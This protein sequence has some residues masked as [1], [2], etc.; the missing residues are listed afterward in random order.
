MEGDG[1]EYPDK[2]GF[3]DTTIDKSDQEMPDILDREE[4]DDIIDAC[5]N[6]RDRAMYKTLY[7][8]GLRAGE[9][10]SLKVGDVNFVDSGVKLNVQGK[11]GSR[12]LLVVESERY[13]RNWLS[14]HPFSNERNAPLWVKVD[15]NNIEE[16]TH[17]DMRLRY[18]YMRIN[19]KRKSAKA[20]VRVER[21]DSGKKSSEVYPHLFRHT[22]ATHLATELTEAAMKEYFGW[23]QGSDQPQTYIHL[24]GR[25]IDGE[26]MKMYGIEDEEEKDQKK[27]CSR[28]MKEYRG[29]ESFCPRCGAPLSQK[30]AMKVEELQNYGQSYVQQRVNGLEMN[31]LEEMIGNF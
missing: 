20:E 10:M 18:D 11:T 15:G 13:L 8:A 30:D 14:K 17:E 3:I 26:I 9:L 5:K 22:R 6:D 29:S 12:K 23:T 25:D 16:K 7:E 21:K 4:I 31:E 24:S 19:L 27:K 1:R 28:C 2:V